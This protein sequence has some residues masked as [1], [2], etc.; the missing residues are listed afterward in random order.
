MSIAQ[1]SKAVKP[2]EPPFPVGARLRHKDGL[3]CRIAKKVDDFDGGHWWLDFEN[4]TGISVPVLL[5]KRDYSMLCVSCGVGLASRAGLCEQC[6]PEEERPEARGE[7]PEAEHSSPNSPAMQE[8]IPLRLIGP[9]P[10]NPRRRYDPESMAELVESIRTHGLLEPILVRTCD[11]WRVNPGARSGQK[12]YFVQNP[13]FVDKERQTYEGTS[14]FFLDADEAERNCPLYEIICGERRWR[15]A[16]GAGLE[17]IHALVRNLDGV[18]ARQLSLV[19]NLVREN[20]DPIEEAEGYKRLQALGHSQTMIAEMVH[21]KQET[22]SNRTRLL[23]L[24]DA[25]QERIRAGE[26]SASHGVA[27]LSMNIES[28]PILT[29]IASAVVEA[30]LPVSTLEK[31]LPSAA[32]DK[33]RK[34]KRLVN[35][36]ESRPKFNVRETCEQACPFEAYRK[37]S[38]RSWEAYCLKPEHYRQLQ[39]GA[40]AEEKT[41]LEREAAE[42]R[43]KGIDD[44]KLVTW[45]Y[46]TLVI[47][48]P[49]P[50]AGCTPDCECRAYSRQLYDNKKIVP[51]CTNRKRYEEEQKAEAEAERKTKLATFELKRALVQQCVEKMTDLA[52]FQPALVLLAQEKLS[53]VRSRQIMFDLLLRYG[54]EIPN[55][56]ARHQIDRNDIFVTLVQLDSM[57]LLQLLVEI[58]ATE[59]LW[60]R[61]GAEYGDDKHGMPMADRLLSRFCPDCGLL[62]DE[63]LC[64]ERKAREER[65]AKEARSEEVAAVAQMKGE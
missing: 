30:K 48:G 55:E 35:L 1:K 45:N 22:I 46:N 23:K 9:S 8:E 50:P 52:D 40:Q 41:A 44:E 5:L 59:E 10:N 62:P 2:A 12:G 28:E 51:V 11:G 19:E 20:I 39:A 4:N 24:P 49:N 64:A 58:N 42:L 53:N 37:S 29:E 56:D 27:L 34:A 65:Q 63:C 26:L 61:F 32:A 7:R 3:T 18:K 15:A 16:R 38:D 6:D 17:T 25:V 13:A 43:E 14:L 31:G 33:L 36:H 54:M 21:R 57:R 47:I 60:W